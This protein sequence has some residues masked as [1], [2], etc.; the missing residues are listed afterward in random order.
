MSFFKI[1]SLRLLRSRL[2]TVAII[3]S[4]LL[5]STI[6]L[7]VFNSPLKGLMNI[8]ALYGIVPTL[9][10]IIT[11]L[12]IQGIWFNE[13]ESVHIGIIKKSKYGVLKL[14]INKVLFYWTI[15]TI[16]TLLILPVILFIGRYGEI[17]YSEVFTIHIGFI[18][19]SFLIVNLGLFVSTFL[20]GRFLIYISIVIP[21]LYL[22]SGSVNS[23]GSFYNGYIKISDIA[24]LTFTGITLFIVSF[25]KIEGWNKK[26]LL[27]LLLF[28]LV[29][30]PGGIDLSRGSRNTLT[31]I[32]EELLE[33]ARVPVSIDYYGTREIKEITMLLN[34]F[35]R[36]P[37][38]NFRKI[39]GESSELEKAVTRFEPIDIGDNNYSFIVIEYLTRNSVI[40]IASIGDTL[41]FDLYNEI[42]FL[43][44]GE[45][46]SVAILLGDSNFQ[47]DD[48]SL[49]YSSIENE[50]Q[51]EFIKKGEHIPHFIDTL[52]LI[53]HRDLGYNDISHIGEYLS[54]G[55]SIIISVNSLDTFGNLEVMDTPLLYA[56]KEAG[57][58]IDPYL[59]GDKRNLGLVNSEGR[60]EPFPL[61][62]IAESTEDIN[63]N[64]LAYPGLDV[65]GIYTSP[66]RINSAS[67]ITLLESSPD[68][69]V[70]DS[71]SGL[72]SNNK[73]ISSMAI[74]DSLILAPFLGGEG[75][76]E[77]KVIVLGT[78][79]SLTNIP[80]DLGDYSP[81][82]FI[83]R[84]L[85]MVQGRDKQLE[86]RQSISYTY[87]YDKA[88]GLF[89][90]L[91]LLLFYPLTVL[92]ILIR[93]QR[94]V[95]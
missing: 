83:Q 33:K 34:E 38:I 66:V 59:I 85:Y 48:F 24:L 78:T 5:I 14:L 27:F 11:P 75:S 57:V 6:Y 22:I 39:I 49:L 60:V 30:I 94:R 35:S 42:D 55:G 90:Y 7:F 3:I 51:V 29:F 10:S 81:Y 45:E 62:L 89:L 58:I 28:P 26:V 15:T 18:F 21:L 74:F 82:E 41:E 13:V 93:V 73:R 50:F 65:L 36:N 64:S 1:E 54:H 92:L 40:P 68:S 71:G 17:V 4:I 32:T 23:I 84:A 67:A 95:S 86:L 19:F 72:Y 37:N 53:G 77:S 56:L 69:W 46:E 20:K 63:D 76:E 87:T 9:L 43:I 52:I 70:V 91:F 47:E 12:F 16:F 44:N 80:G 79:R 88:P 31:E 8:K 61:N 25:I 2:F